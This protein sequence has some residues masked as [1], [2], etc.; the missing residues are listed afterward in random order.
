[1]RRQ[2]R[3]SS[4]GTSSGIANRRGAAL[5]C[6]LV[7]AI[8]ISLGAASA[9]ADS[10]P[11]VTIAGPTAVTAT[12]AHVSGT[13]DPQG[14]PSVT[15]WHF[16]YSNDPESGAWIQMA[17]QSAGSGTGAVPVEEELKAL[18]PNTTYSVRLVAIN[19]EGADRVETEAPYPTFTTEAV[20]PAVATMPGFALQGGATALIG[21]S[22]NPKSSATTYWL[23]YG[24]G[25]GYGQSVPVTRDASAGSGA[26]A[27]VFAEEIAGLTPQTTYHFRLVAENA[28]GKSEGAD[29]T[30][31][32]APAG[33]P[34]APGC[35]NEQ[36]RLGTA[37][38]G[39]PDCRAYEQVSPVA[40][41]NG[42][43]CFRCD[44]AVS[45]GA[46]DAL[47]FASTVAF[48]GSPVGSFPTNYISRRSDSGTPKN[49]GAR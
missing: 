42:N 28:T 18:H 37:A 30:F 20:K 23:E 29:L 19:E 16:E 40:K 15:L 48:P 32:S 11:V 38:A 25:E 13:V 12:T 24:P 14:G 22:V 2:V 36:F 21:G 5:L 8:T 26:E 17:S 43:V 6:G 46:G 41:N 39:L 44:T 45:A 49:S 10:P 3:A 4:A 31:E 33:P 7:L 35:P 34:A 9:L 1:L 47:A 27:V